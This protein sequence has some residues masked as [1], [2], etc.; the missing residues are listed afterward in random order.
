MARLIKRDYV[1]KESKEI[2]RKGTTFEGSPEKLKK[3]VELGIVSEIWTGDELT[4]EQIKK[5]LDQKEVEYKVSS[6]K[7]GLLKA[8]NGAD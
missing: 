2:I 5:M 3:L 4:K 6:T 8:L 1:D 7:E